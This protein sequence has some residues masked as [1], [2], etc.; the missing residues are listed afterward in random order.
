MQNRTLE[1]LHALATDA[2]ARFEATAREVEVEDPG[3]A[4]AAKL[5]GAI[6]AGAALVLEGLAA[7]H[8]A[9]HKPDGRGA[10]ADGRKYPPPHSVLDWSVVEI[11]HEIEALQKVLAVRRGE[12]RDDA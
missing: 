9:Q 2:V 12:P 10:G 4:L 1:E 3:T 7:R 8:D 6:Y 5:G 11:E